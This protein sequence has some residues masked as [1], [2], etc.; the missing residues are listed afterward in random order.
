MTYAPENT[1]AAHETAYQ[2]GARC[3]EFDVR[4]TQ[5][6]H[7]IV[8]H[9][10]DADRTTSGCGNV[11]N[12]TLAEI[13]KF[14]AG[15]YKGEAFKGERVPTL[16]DALRNVKGRFAVDIDF[17]AGPKHSA[18]MLDE[19]LEEEGFMNDGSPLVTIFARHNHFALLRS[20][21]PKHALRPH[22]LGRRH[23]RKMVKE[24]EIEI[25][26]LRRYVFS[27][28][29]ARNIRAHGLHL[30]SNTMSDE[31]HNDYEIS[32]ASAAK[33]GSLFIQTDFIDHLVQYL[34]SIDRLET[35]VLGRDYLPIEPT[36]P[37]TS[38]LD[39]PAGP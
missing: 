11:E 27:F 18:E 26:G 37:K 21:A 36:T 22:Y 1:I 39:L 30:F 34:K 35:R 16:R 8:F 3:I 4:C 6:G 20:L 9:D 12:L 23:A 29:A 7:F 10:H 33:A 25:M 14:D 31:E 5:D 24:H 19:I 17:K 2:M 15:S 38:G 13:Q 28:A 32:Y